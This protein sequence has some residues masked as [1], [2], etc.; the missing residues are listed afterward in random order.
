MLD[1]PSKCRKIV[2]SLTFVCVL[3]YSV[4]AQTGKKDYVEYSEVSASFYCHGSP[5]CTVKSKGI[6]ATGT[7]VKRGTIAVDPKVIP[8]R[9]TI[10]IVEPESIAGWY[11]SEDTGGKRIKG[12]FLDIWVPTQKEAM[13][14]GLY[15]K[16]IVLR[17]YP[18]G[19]KK[20][21]LEKEEVKDNVSKD[22]NIN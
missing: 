19:F 21:D 15:K 20:E 6:T 1:L 5:N 18:K 9:R 3:L 10:Q 14:K 7:K 8:L 16:N 4:S 11:V 12:K 2:F 13:Q 17:V 22:A